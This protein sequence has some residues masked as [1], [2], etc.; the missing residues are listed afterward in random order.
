MSISFIFKHVNCIHATK[1]ILINLTEQ[2]NL[3]IIIGL[4]NTLR[5]ETH[6]QTHKNLFLLQSMTTHKQDNVLKVNKLFFYICSKSKC[7]KPPK[8]F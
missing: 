3:S 7:L 1:E 2:L 5:E 4:V 6:I 8:V